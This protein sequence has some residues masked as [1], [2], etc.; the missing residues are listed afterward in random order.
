MAQSLVLYKY[1][2][3]GECL[4]WTKS[5]LK[6]IKSYGQMYGYLSGMSIVIIVIYVIKKSN[7]QN[8]SEY[9]ENLKKQI[10]IALHL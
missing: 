1:K 7:S 3:F 2:L 10:L 6:K 5:I 9:I 4:T 8:L